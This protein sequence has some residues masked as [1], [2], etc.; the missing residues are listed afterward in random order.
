MQARK[1]ISELTSN[2]YYSGLNRRFDKRAKLLVGF[3][4]KYVQLAPQIAAFVRPCPYL[5]NR[6][7]IILAANVSHEHNVAFLMNLREY[8]RRS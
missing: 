8:L 2:Q 3:G 4:F 5:Y 6:Q 1:K 7:Q